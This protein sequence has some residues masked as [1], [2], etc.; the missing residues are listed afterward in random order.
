MRDIQSDKIDTSHQILRPPGWPRPRGYA[1]G[2]A[3]RGRI[4]CLGGQIGWDETETLKSGFIPQC[5]QALQ[6]IVALLAEAGATPA[7]LV[8]MTWYVVDIDLYNSLLPE[9]GQVYRDT[10]GKNFPAMALVQVVNLVETGAL[11]EI[12]ATAV[13]ND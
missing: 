2:I 9:L 6:N 5:R 12:E 3:A 8:R 10:L 7:N 1:H 4:I 11:V 13:I